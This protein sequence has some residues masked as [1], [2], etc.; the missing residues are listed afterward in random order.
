LLFRRSR[1]VPPAARRSMTT[2]TRWIRSL[3]LIVA[4]AGLGFLGGSIARALWLDAS[5]SPAPTAALAID[6]TADLVAGPAA[7]ALTVRIFGDYECPACRQLE[8]RL[9]DTLRAIAST[10]RMRLV[11]FHR[12]L[13]ARRDADLAAAAVACEPDPRER[14][15]L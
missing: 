14:W 6:H 8:L 2:S 5:T 3:L 13:A 7:A 4:L 9:G 12:P 15:R 1:R 11:Y 10:G